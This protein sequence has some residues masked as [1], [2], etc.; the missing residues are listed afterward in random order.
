MALLARK[1]ENSTPWLGKLLSSFTEKAGSDGRGATI[2]QDLN[3]GSMLDDF[4]STDL[5]VYSGSLT[6]PPC[7]EGVKWG[8]MRARCTISSR[9]LDTILRF[10]HGRSVRPLQDINAR[11]IIRFPPASFSSKN[12][13][14]KMSADVKSKITS[15]L[16]LENLN[17]SSDVK[18]KP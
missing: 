9:D 10:Q 18:P 12:P 7:S 11:P 6:T 3:V 13:I 8:V 16:K 17:K 5:F 2:F 4:S 14:S 15:R 1:A